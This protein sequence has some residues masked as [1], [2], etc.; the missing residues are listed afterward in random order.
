[1]N[2]THVTLLVGYLP[3][4]LLAHLVGDWFIQTEYEALNKALGKFWNRALMAHCAKYTLCFVPV[5]WFFEESQ[6][7]LLLILG[8]HLLID[9]R[10]PV[11]WLRRHI[12]RSSESGIKNTFWI[13]IV[14]DQIFHF[15]ILM[16]LFVSKMISVHEVFNLNH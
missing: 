14:I 6:L 8:S 1:M 11:I 4:L 13:T 9:R 7:W 3:F 2:T 15:V 10:S 16:M 12:A 5:L